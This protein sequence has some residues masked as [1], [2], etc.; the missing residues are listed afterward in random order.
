MYQTAH[1]KVTVTRWHVMSGIFE[2]QTAQNSKISQ[3][4]CTK[5]MQNS[6]NRITIL[7]GVAPS[8]LPG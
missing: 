2:G 5:T 8:K 3:K 7:G 6:P 1:S 4:C